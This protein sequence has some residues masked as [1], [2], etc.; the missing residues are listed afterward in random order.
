MK[1]VIRT[2]ATVKRKA[3]QSLS[4]WPAPRAE[5]GEG[6]V[7]NHVTG[8]LTWV[9]A[10]GKML[11]RLA[12]GDGAVESFALPHYPGSFAHC[13]DGHILMAYR[14]GL[15]IVDL[16]AGTSVDL[17]CAGVDFALERFN[18]GAC[19]R[20][21]RFWIGTM[22]PR[23]TEPAGALYRVDPDLSIRKMASGVRVSNGLAFSPDDTVMYHTDS[24]TALIYAYDFDLATGEIANRRVH[25][26][27]R[28]TGGGRPDGITADAD[29]NLWMAMNGG[30]R[31]LCIAPD[32]THAAE[33]GL[34]TDRPTSLCFGGERLD[35]LFV[36]SMQYGLSDDQR[37]SQPEA[38]CLLELAPGATGLQEPFFAG[39][40]SA[41]LKEAR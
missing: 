38:G 13:H 25:A 28:E 32:G 5:L 23:M 22:D 35:R 40:A 10:A 41:M 2:T 12:A 9:D 29:G 8:T 17:P 39:T 16:E 3:G 36:T 11:H 6:P 18:D 24:R 27:F 14:N 33:I 19:D 4:H 1:P 37:L 31:V 21:G 15:A 7:W 34:P 26:D 20:A 30:A